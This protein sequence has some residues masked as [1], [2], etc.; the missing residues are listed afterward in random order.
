[1]IKI[2][3]VSTP[4]GSSLAAAPGLAAVRGLLLVFSA[5][6][7]GSIPDTLAQTSLA[8]VSASSPQTLTPLQREI[9][10]QRSRLNSSDVEERRDAVLRLGALARPDSSRV[11]AAALTDSAAIVRATAARSILSLPPGEAVVLLVPLLNDKNEFVRREAAYALG[12]TRSRTAVEPLVAALARDKEAGVRGAAAVSLGM[13]KDEAAV[14]ALSE[15]LGRR[16][17]R[18]GFLNRITFRKREEN[19]FVRRAAVV[20]LG[21]IGSREAVPALI[22]V[23]SN[24][25]AGDDVRREAARAL[26]LIGDVAAVPALRAVVTASDPYLSQIAVEAL[27]KLKSVAPLS[28]KSKVI[29]QS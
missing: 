16:I 17:A 23:L 4:H 2:E 13:I 6:I 10:R 1:M 25:R 18:A 14:P 8:T 20:A 3:N 12:E 5:L 21:Q 29:K 7:A 19:D 9:E 11:A 24:E 26:G 28:P 15:A 22:A 27:R